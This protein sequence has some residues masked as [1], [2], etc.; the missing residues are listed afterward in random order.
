MP[1]WRNGRRGGLKIRW[2]QP[3]G[4]ST[5]LVGTKLS[6]QALPDSSQVAFAGDYFRHLTRVTQPVGGA[7]PSSPI[8]LAPAGP[9]RE[10]TACEDPGC[11]TGRRLRAGECRGERRGKR[12]G[13]AG[14]RTGQG[15]KTRTRVSAWI[16][17]VTWV[18]FVL[19]MGAAVLSRRSGS[20][21]DVFFGAGARGHGLVRTFVVILI[22][23]VAA[24][25]VAG[26]LV[27][28]V[29][30]LKKRTWAWWL[31]VAVYIA[32]VPLLLRTA[33]RAALWGWGGVV[34]GLFFGLPLLILLTDRPRGW[35][36]P[37][38]A[39]AHGDPGHER[40]RAPRRRKTQPR[41]LAD[42]LAL[43]AAKAQ[44]NRERRTTRAPRD[45]TKRSPT[46]VEILVVLMILAILGA[47][48]GSAIYHARRAG[49]ALQ[50]SRHAPTSGKGQDFFAQPKRSKEPARSPRR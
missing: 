6:A 43:V 40:T 36:E 42:F 14:N 13:F 47:I 39:K 9:A 19:V 41:T 35:R 46:V 7:F 45:G 29:A 20:G 22:V 33:N 3:H 4:G 31:L 16:A 8:M 28:W 2:G 24:S 48:V 34:L 17:V 12:G 38:S 26:P 30:L 25:F 15:M 32:W 44:A 5:P 11:R 18:I 10:T 21:A 37:D 23:L 49:P 50:P 27:G 1:T